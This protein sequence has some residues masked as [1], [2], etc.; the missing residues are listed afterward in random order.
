M[1]KRLRHTFETLEDRVDE[2]T[3]ALETSAEIS[4]RLTAILDLNELLRYVVNHLQSEFNFYH[5]HIFLLDDKREKLIATEGVGQAGVEI[6]TGGYSIRLDA[7]KSLVAR[8]ARTCEIVIVDNVHETEDWL[9]HPLLPNTRSEMAIPITLGVE[10]EVV[11]VLDVQENKIASFDEGDANLLRSLANQVGVAIHNA[12]LYSLAQQEL[13][14]RVRAEEQLQQALQETEGLLAA[15]Q[16]ILGATHLKNICYTLTSHFN[17]LVQADRTTLLLLDRDRKQ[18][19]FAIAHGSIEGEIPLSYEEMMV[20]I[21]G[22]VLKSKQPIISLSADDG[23][24]PEATRARRVQ[25]KAGPLIVV[26]IVTKTADGTSTVIGTTTAINLPGQREFTQHDAN[27]LMALTTQAAAVIE[28]VR[29]FEEAQAARKSA[30]VANQAKSIFLAN[31]SH[32]LRTPLNATILGFSQLMAHSP[33][34]EQTD[35]ENL[36]IIGRSGEHLLNLINDVL[37]LSKIEASR[38]ELQSEE[39][40]LHQMRL[41]LEEMFRLHAE[42]KGLVLTLEQAENVPQY[43]RADE[44]KLRQVLINLLDNA[45]KFTEKGGITL[46][47]GGADEEHLHHP[48]HFEV[49][50]TGVGIAPDE[51]PAVFDAFVQ[52]SSGQQSQQGTGL[53]LSISHR[54]VRMMGGDLIVRSEVGK[55]AYFQFDVQIEA[56]DAAAVEVIRSTSRVI[57][58]EPGQRASDGGPYRLLIAEDTETNRKLLVKLLQPLGFEVREAVNGREAVEMWEARRPHLIW[59][60]MQ[61]PVMN[62]YEA[63]KQIKATPEGQSTIII[64]L[65]ASAFAEDRDKVLAIGCDDFVRKPFHEAEIFDKIATHLGVRY[66][67]KEE[68]AAY[69]A[70]AGE[71]GRKSLAATD[72]AALPPELLADLRQA[73]K[74]INI[75]K[76]NTVIEQIGRA[77]KPLAQALADLVEN[78]R[79]DTLQTL[80]EEIK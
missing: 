43:M 21:S 64:A 79:F 80:V 57:G 73:A 37:E 50:D 48:L 24:E 34:L 32:E 28:N 59:M 38:V 11:G 44:N 46:R 42:R 29:L 74:E 22:M 20:G 30:E 26:P 2:R 77:N 51:L 12:Q 15:A 14:E 7:P 27:L 3:H 67:Y 69:S 31:M 6:K 5:I 40:D 72:L 63:T 19:Q 56:V 78:F 66:L 4:Q 61:M 47:V 71:N 33:T 41:S 23:I 62:G 8:A 9:P 68:T 13:A 16:A 65:T 36:A 39:F 75:E 10:A 35:K 58:L 52:T 54:F 76:A 45:V 53:G 49:E 1:A 70:R 60:D 25:E 18:I 17:E 55:G